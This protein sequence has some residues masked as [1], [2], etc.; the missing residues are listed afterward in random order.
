MFA[1]AT[2]GRLS[3]CLSVADIWRVCLACRGLPSVGVVGVVG[4]FVCVIAWRFVCLSK[5]GRLS[6]CRGAWQALRV[7]LRDIR[8]SV[9]NKIP[10]EF[11]RHFQNFSD[12]ILTEFLLFVAVCLTES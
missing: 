11:V 5:R 2:L 8:T 1:L 4:L 12:R 3:P 7:L 6:P 9:S 10:N